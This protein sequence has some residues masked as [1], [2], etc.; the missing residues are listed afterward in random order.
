KTYLHNEIYTFASLS[1]KDFFLK[2]G[3]ELIRENKV[4]KEGQN[5]KKFLM[6]KDVVYKN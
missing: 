3:F 4:I 6:K 2:N 1:A 5:L